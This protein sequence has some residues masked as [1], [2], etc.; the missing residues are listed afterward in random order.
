MGEGISDAVMEYM[1]LGK[2]VIATDGGGTKELVIDN[3]TGYL[4]KP[5]SAKDLARKILYLL[6][7]HETAKSKREDLS[8]N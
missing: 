2:P 1:A 8:M 7:H 3:S 6:E 5:E 4:I